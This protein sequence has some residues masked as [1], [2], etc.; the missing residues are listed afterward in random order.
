MAGSSLG[1]LISAYAGYHYS[2]TF[3]RVACVSPSYWWDNEHMRADA[4]ALGRPDLVRWYQDMGTAEGSGAIDDLRA[5]RD[6]LIVQ[7]FQLGVDLTSI[8]AQGHAH[9]E[10]YWAQ[11]VPNML[12]FLIGRPATTGVDGP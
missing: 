2:G 11:R 7:G 1:G 3:R 10:S 12:R 6:V 5:M 9:N 4:Q 8:E